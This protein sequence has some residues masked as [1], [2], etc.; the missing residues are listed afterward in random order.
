MITDFLLTILPSDRHHHGVPSANH[1]S[2]FPLSLRVD[3]DKESGQ[4]ILRGIGELHLEIVCDKL[5]R[6]FNIEVTTGRAYV[7]YR[8]SIVAG[9]DDGDHDDDGL[10]NKRHVYDRTLGG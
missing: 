8:E 5:K 3:T 10:T 1:P 2:S 9:N 6:Q 4:T 7:N